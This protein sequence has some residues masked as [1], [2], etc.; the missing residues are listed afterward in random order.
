MF[1]SEIAKEIGVSFEGEDIE[2][3]GIH[4]LSEADNT[5]ISFLDNI[6]YKDQLSKTNAVAVLCEEK[7]VS[8]LPKGVIALITDEPYLKLALASKL[9]THKIT[10]KTSTPHLGK[11]CDIDKSVVF[12]SNVI[13]EDNVVILANC[14]IGDNVTIKAGTLLHANATIYHHCAVGKD[15]IIHSGTVIGSDGFGFAHTKD[16]RHV[17]IYQNGNVFIGDNVEIGANCAIDRAVF[18]TTYIMD[19]VKLDN[20]IQIGHNCEI[21]AHSLLVAQS[22]IAGSTKTGRNVV[23]G[24]QSATSG[25]LAIGDFVQIAG[26]SGVTK[27]LESGKTYAGFPAIEHK[28]WLRNQAKL[29]SLLKKSKS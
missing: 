16:G 26:K 20:L 6:R 10:T 19:G 4:T 1:L 25:H 22:G 23:F 21:G 2:I 9:F 29:S 7:Y 11:N 14:Y 18:G 17:K 24:G 5:Q 28:E 8:L 3:L 27:S 13:I 12:G 15:C